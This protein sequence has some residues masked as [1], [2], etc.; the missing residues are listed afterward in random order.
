MVSRS[1]AS[2]WMS[3]ARCSSAPTMMPLTIGVASRSASCEMLTSTSRLG[4]VARG[5]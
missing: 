5:S 4:P 2:T 3:L 1:V